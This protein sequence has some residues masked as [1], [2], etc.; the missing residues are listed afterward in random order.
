MR[1]SVLKN[2]PAYDPLA[3]EFMVLL[4]GMPLND[5]VTADEERGEAL[6]YVRPRAP[7]TRWGVQWLVGKV[8]IL[9]Q[10]CA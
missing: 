2:D 10:G 9:K 3:G 8:E 6:V 1:K 4:D 7:F 5:C